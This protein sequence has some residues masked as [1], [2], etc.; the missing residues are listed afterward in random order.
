MHKEHIKYLSSQNINISSFIEDSRK[1]NDTL[2]LQ[3]IS[4][5]SVIIIAVYKEALLRK[6]YKKIIESGFSY[7]N[8]IELI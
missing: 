6:V 5:D 7:K 2:E 3:N 1:D 4:K 8:I